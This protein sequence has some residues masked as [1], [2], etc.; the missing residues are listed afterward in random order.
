MKNLYAKKAITSKLSFKKILFTVVLITTCFS[1]YSQVLKE[2]E[3]RAAIATPTQTVYNIKGDFAMIGN[4]NLTLVNYNDTRANDSAMRYVDIDQDSNTLN[5][6]SARLEFPVE[7]GSIPECSKILFAGLYWVGRA[8]NG[9]DANLDGDNDPN[10]FVINGKTLNKRKVKIKG[11]L[12]TIYTE[13]EATPDNIYFPDNAYQNIFTAYVDITQYVID[14]NGEGDYVIAD[15]ALREGTIDVTGY[16]GGWGMVVVYE[17]SKMKYRNVTVFDGHAFV[18]SGVNQDFS[19]DVD[20]FNAVQSGDVNIRLGLM[21]SE[22]EFDFGGDYFEIEELNSGNYRTLANKSGSTDNFFDST[23]DYGGSPGSRTPE[24]VNNTGLD[25]VTYN[26]P[27]SD[28]SIIG[29]GQTSTSFNYGS[30]ND[31]FV[32]FNV[33]FSVDAYIPDVDGILTTTS[34]SATPPLAPNE[35]A[36]YTIEIRNKGTEAT[37]N[38]IITIPI[39]DN[40]NQSDLEITSNV[41]APLSTTNTPTYNQNLGPNGSIVWDL[42]TLPL[43]NDP[44]TVLADISFKLT[45]TTDCSIL[46]DNSFDPNISLLGTIEGIGS[47]SNIDFNNP[48]IQG[49]E[50][51]GLCIG[52]PI[53][54]PSLIEIDYL[55]YI[56]EPPVIV[57]PGDIP[58]NVDTGADGAVVNYTTPVGTDNSTGAVTTQIAGLASGSLFPVGTTTNTFRVTDAA[59]NTAEC[60]FDVTITDNEA[61]SIVCP[62]DINQT[63]DANQ[64]STTISIINPTAFDNCSSTFIF[65]GTRSDNLALTEEFPV[66]LTTITWTATDEANNISST[67]IQSINITDDE[68]P[69]FVETLPVDITVECDNIPQQ[70]VLTATD[71]CS[72]VTVTPSEERIDGKCSSYYQLKRTWTT[73]DANNNTTTHTQTITVE[74]TTPPVLTLPANVSAECSDDLSPIAFGTATAIDNCDANPIITF[75]DV[76]EDGACI[77]TFKI[78]RTW[79]ATDAC[80]NFITADQTIST[81]D[82]TA[83]EF[84]QTTL[85]QDLTVECSSI[86][87]AEI[88]TATDNCGSATVEVE[89]KRVDGDCPNNYKITRTWT[90]TDECGLTKTHVQT[91]TVVDITPP[92]FVETSLPE[93]TTVECDAIPTAETLTATD[94]CGNA[95]VTLEDVRTD[96]DCPYNYTIARTWT[97]TDEC[98]LTTTHTQVITV[99]DTTPP[100]FVETSLPENITV[101]CD[102]IP[103]AETLTATDNCGDAIVSVKEEITEGD[104][105][106]NYIISR[107]WTATDECGLMTS[108]TQTITVEDTE[109]PVPS[110]TFD[111]TLNVSCTDIPEAPELEFTDNCSSD[112]NIIVVFNETNTYVENVFEDYVIT[113][114]WTVRDECQNESVYTQTLNVV[115]DEVIID[116]VA[117]DVCFD[118]GAV[119]LNNLTPDELNINGTWELLE[120]DSGAIL[121]GNIFDPTNIEWDAETVITGMNYKFRYTT[122]DQGCISITEIDVVVNYCKVLPCGENDVVISKAVTPNGDAYNEFFEISG[123]ELCGFRYDVKI[124][125]RWGALIYEADDYQNDWNGFAHKS[126]VGTAGKVPN[127]TYYYIVNIKD[128]GLNPITGPVYLGTK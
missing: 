62:D 106:N 67:C 87:N 117:P 83:P 25:I 43:P 48:L 60:S 42:G 7:N 93:N 6:S 103:T 2:F 77:G 61:P 38:T 121:T 44:D 69:I 122:T 109:A 27:N 96:G 110:S 10:T 104:C 97:A 98:G 28:K 84:E 49:Y 80:G 50:T 113:R 127:G 66:G 90:A 73:V 76:R 108:H 13:V 11:P 120:G 89:D 75:E 86:P 57:C 102:A 118:E 68:A 105:P 82:M 39:P 36:N 79:T 94:T 17:N 15:M 52:D 46:S 37:N 1:S 41:Y 34:T 19:F 45:V 20:G 47:I 70:E 31:T 9:P 51:S 26:I 78:T 3:A 58:Q 63:A 71:N 56:N 95:T 24:L 74:D 123:I 115:L 35:S 5:S 14:N 107:I 59:G 119:D 18:D 4:T 65:N 22:G 116:M 53:P 126:S 30:T 124:F 88:L 111:E 33:T 112:S 101:E 32:I 91:I 92:T 81:S 16:S 125:N 40:V 12:Q 29:N 8:D 21:A 114:T 99:Q 64:C 85:P 23:I 55:D 72:S 100:T 128:S 54:V